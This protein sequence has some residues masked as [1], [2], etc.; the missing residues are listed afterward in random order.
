VSLREGV[1]EPSGPDTYNAYRL[2]LESLQT[3]FSKVSNKLKKAG[4]KVS[5]MKK[6]CLRLDRDARVLLGRVYTAEAEYLRLDFLMNGNRSRKEVG[7]KEVPLPYDRLMVAYR[8]LFTT[9]G[10][11]ETHQQNLILAGEELLQLKK[12]VETLSGETLPA[13][14]TALEEAGAPH[15][16]D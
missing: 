1:L 9:Y 3:E 15:V 11:T 5:A 13:L 8:G 7:E 4:Q 2:E 6:A 16:A 12:D 14:Q 10:P